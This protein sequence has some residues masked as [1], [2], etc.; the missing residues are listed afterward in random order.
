V[1]RLILL[2]TA[3]APAHASP[4]LEPCR[5]M[6]IVHRGVAM[7]AASA[8]QRQALIGVWTT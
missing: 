4:A 8:S 1:L 6:R 7:V 3:P 2:A 5:A